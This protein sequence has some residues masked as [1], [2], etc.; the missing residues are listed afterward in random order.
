MRPRILFFAPFLAALAFSCSASP[1]PEKSGSSSGAIIGGNL[2]TT[3][4]AVVAVYQESSTDGA[5]CSGTFIKTDPTTKVGY[6][7]TAAHCVQ[8]S[9]P[10]VIVLQGDDYN[11]LG[12]TRYD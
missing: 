2:D 9:L 7:L 10:P 11:A 6:V 4:Q 3:H 1:E 8:S 12:I 5:I